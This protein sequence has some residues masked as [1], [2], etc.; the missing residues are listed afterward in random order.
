[1]PR[2]AQRGITLCMGGAAGQRAAG[3]PPSVVVRGAAEAAAVLRLAQGRGVTLLSAPGAGG[4]LGPRGWRAL[5]AAARAAAPGATPADLL[6]CGDAAGFALAALRAGCRGLVLD[7]ACPAFAAVAGAAE[8]AGA[9][10]LPARPPAFD[11][12]GLDLRRPGAAARLRA[13]LDAAP[14]DS[15]PAAG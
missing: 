4:A 6:C 15:A 5:V 9:L 12:I 11:P 3:L 10:L 7:A 1:L 8:E 13:W 2:F 14:D